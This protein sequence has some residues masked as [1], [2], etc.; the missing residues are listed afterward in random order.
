M[1]DFRRIKLGCELSAHITSMWLAESDKIETIDFVMVMCQAI[2]GQIVGAAK[3]LNDD[4]VRLAKVIHE[5]TLKFI[6]K[7]K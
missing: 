3:D 4:P 1:D 5:G 6:E 7:I 2:S